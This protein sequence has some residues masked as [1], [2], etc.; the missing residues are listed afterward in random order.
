MLIKYCGNHFI[1][2]S[3]H[4]AVHFRFIQCYILY[5]NITGNYIIRNMVIKRVR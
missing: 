1:I 3:G 4:Y 2:K 5:L